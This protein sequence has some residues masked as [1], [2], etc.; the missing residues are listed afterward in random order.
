MKTIKKLLVTRFSALGDVAMV[1]PVLE[2]LCRA[3]PDI[4][5]TFLT[6][7]L[8]EKIART[9]V[10][11]LP[12]LTVRGL[13]L[14][15]DYKGISGLNALYR[16]LRLERYDAVADLHNV[17]RTI[18][19]SYRFRFNRVTVASIHKGRNEK[20][21]LVKHT[22]RRQLI[23]S[24]ERYRQVFVRL[25]LDFTI[26]YDAAA[27]GR[28]LIGQHTS[29]APSATSLRIGIA[30]FAQH[31]G[32]IYPAVQM[33]R[34]IDLLLSSGQDVELYLFGGPN[35]KEELDAWCDH[36]EHI[37]NLAGAQ[38]ID[39]DLLVMAGLHAMISMDSANMHLASLV[40]TPVV[41]L[42]G[43]THPYAGFLGFGQ[44]EE[45][46]LQLPLECRPCSIYGNKPCPLHDY[47]CLTGIAPEAV[48]SQTL[49]VASTR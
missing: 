34:V 38:G 26:Q 11:H 22:I 47:R 35:E 13:N 19:L 37:H 32:K 44:S 43:A 15:R 25:G 39:D 27:H 9:V 23:S 48:V 7:P 28:M 21:A 16:T 42:W 36:R 18:W 31:L 8:G 2:S 12:N 6:N 17:L 1:I 4:E 46:V 29:P 49:K 30:P 5:V 3:Y 10:G 41:S 45:N 24:F 40:G 20:R 14:K 33:K